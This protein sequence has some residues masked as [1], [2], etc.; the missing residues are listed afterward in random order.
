MI[1][2]DIDG[3]IINTAPATYKTFELLGQSL[4]R[5]DLP[6]I[7]QN[8]SDITSEELFFKMRLEDISFQDFIQKKHQLYD[9]FSQ[10]LILNEKLIGWLEV[11]EHDIMLFSNASERNV[12]RYSSLLC[13]YFDHGILDWRRMGYK[14]KCQLTTADLK[15]ITNSLPEDITLIDDSPRVQRW[16]KKMG[17][18]ICSELW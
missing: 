13:K 6:E 15:V 10:D 8:N 11:S 5:P 17:M 18:N 1:L 4:G 14:E 12:A 2:L 3:T 7:Y 16:G 9:R